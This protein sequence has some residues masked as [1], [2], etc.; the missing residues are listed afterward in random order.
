MFGNIVSCWKYGHVNY[1]KCLHLTVNPSNN[2]TNGLYFYFQQQFEK[3]CEVAVTTVIYSQHTAE[4]EPYLQQ[5]F[6]L[7]SEKYRALINKA[8]KKEVNSITVV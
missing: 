5:V 1:Y 2:E 3:S 4:L 8:K 7:T 6:S